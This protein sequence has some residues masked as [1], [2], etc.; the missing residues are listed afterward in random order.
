MDAGRSQPSCQLLLTAGNYGVKDTLR[1][2]CMGRFFT[3]AEHQQIVIL[4]HDKPLFSYLPLP[5]EQVAL[6][7][8]V[9]RLAARLIVVVRGIYLHLA[10]LVCAP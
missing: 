4:L 9:H 3:P 5:A 2:E 10:H 1:V 8:R 7:K 6:E